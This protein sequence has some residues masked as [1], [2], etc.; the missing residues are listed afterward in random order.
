MAVSAADCIVCELEQTLRARSN[1]IRCELQQMNPVTEPNYERLFQ[2]LVEVDRDL[3]TL[4]GR[5]RKQR[6]AT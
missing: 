5:F 2:M 6:K 4:R 3:G 1:K